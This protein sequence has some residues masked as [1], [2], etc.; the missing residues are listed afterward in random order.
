MFA[1]ETEL[2]EVVFELDSSELTARFE[3][4]T[5]SAPTAKLQSSGSLFLVL[6]RD[7]SPGLVEDISPPH[8]HGRAYLW[9]ELVSCLESL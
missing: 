8:D 3:L 9:H 1:F 6:M 2:C 5:C 4:D 7:V